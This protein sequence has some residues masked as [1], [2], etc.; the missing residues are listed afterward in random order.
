[1]TQWGSNVRRC[2]GC[3]TPIGPLTTWCSR[4]CW[5]ADEGPER[6]N[7]EVDNMQEERV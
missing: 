3:L 4:L 2:P 7:D 6:D 5:I 1:M